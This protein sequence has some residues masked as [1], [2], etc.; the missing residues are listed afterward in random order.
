MVSSS[1][2]YLAKKKKKKN[3][4]ENKCGVYHLQTK[5]KQ[6]VFGGKQG[7]FGKQTPHQGKSS[8]QLEPRNQA[9]LSIHVSRAITMSTLLS[10]HVSVHCDISMRVISGKQKAMSGDTLMPPVA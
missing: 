5:N 6:A 8:L 2:F 7:E 1:D 4:K 9:N 10:F 3:R